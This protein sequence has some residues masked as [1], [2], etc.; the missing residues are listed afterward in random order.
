MKR[1]ISIVLTVSLLVCCGI[2]GVQ[3]GKVYAL[4]MGVRK[5]SANSTVT[6]GSSIATVRYTRLSDGTSGVADK[7][8]DV[9]PGEEFELTT[10]PAEEQAER[11]A[12]IGWF[13]GNGVLL[14]EGGN[15]PC[16]H[17]RV[18]G[19]ICR[20][21]RN[22]VPSYS[23]LYMQRRGQFVRVVRLAGGTGRRLHHPD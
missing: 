14:S 6:D 22:C 8:F 13:D 23:D 10:M 1:F 19:G 9:Q 20:L 5:Y 4:T 12:F 17:E 21:C 11:Y 2:V 18:K 15:D 7:I 3:A 16:R